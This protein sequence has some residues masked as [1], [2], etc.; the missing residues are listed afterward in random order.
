F[1]G[2]D[3]DTTAVDR[4][5]FQHTRARARVGKE[6]PPPAAPR[7]GLRQ[8][9]GRVVG[10]V[11]PTGTHRT[12]A[13]HRPPGATHPMP[14]P[15]RPAPAL[16]CALAVRLAPAARGE[17]LSPVEEQIARYAATHRAEAE[18]LLETA[19]SIPSATKDLD[20]VRAVGKV[21]DAELARVGFKTRWE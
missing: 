3:P 20:G 18:A 21:F 6:P 17:G 15:L 9:A 12:A 10:M 11:R 13:R 7:R 14:R 1:F 4:A 8:G 5:P 19:V 2:T 16:V